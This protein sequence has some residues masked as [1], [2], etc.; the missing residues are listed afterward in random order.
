MT[1]PLVLLP[2]M[3]CDMRVFAPQVTAFSHNRTVILSPVTAGGSVAAMARK[4]LEDAPA[5]FALAGQGLGGIVAMDMLRQAPE[6]ITRLA[7][8]NTTPLAETPQEAAARE[9]RIVGARAGRLDD[10]IVEEVPST[11]LAPGPMRASVSATMLDMVRGL[12]AE[13]YQA[14]LRAMQRRPDQQKVLRMTRIPALILCG[15][16][17]TIYP[18]RRHEFMAELIP[19]ATLVVLEGAGHMPLL[20]QP[21]AVTDALQSWLGA[22]YRLT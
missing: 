9:L 11:C 3:F 21:D 4:A 8:I 13:V 2:D 6:R 16:Y 10:M 5:R 22:P 14:Q 20:E 15:A 17:D 12:G 18:M 19:N 7:L 1:E